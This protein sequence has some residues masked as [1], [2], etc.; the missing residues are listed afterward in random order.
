[1]GAEVAKIGED[2]NKTQV[3][4]EV[5]LIVHYPSRWTVAIGRYPDREV[6]PAFEAAGYHDELHR[7][8]YSTDVVDPT[9][10]LD[11]YRLVI[12]PRLWMV[13]DEAA[14]NLEQYVKSGGTLVLTAGSGVTDQYGVSFDT[15]R[16]GP[17]AELAGIE[18]SDIAWD[19]D[20][21]ET[22]SSDCITTLGGAGAL[23]PWDEIHV[24]DAEVLATYGSGWRKGSPAI[25]RN[26][27]GKG[28]VIYIGSRLD[29]DALRPVVHWLC[30]ETGAKPVLKTPDGVRAYERRGESESFLFLINYTDAVQNID[31]PESWRDAL[32]TESLGAVE[33]EPV[34]VRILRKAL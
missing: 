9:R 32:G 16:P 31:L 1:M 24:T 10:P 11:K 33:I 23:C 2:L 4:A 8:N 26:T 21:R 29:S 34:D 14:A 12:A 19:K 22:L 28:Q 27:Y 30:T 7:T 18:V 3:E 25:T 15:P 5:A 6:D 20:R 13:D 17:L